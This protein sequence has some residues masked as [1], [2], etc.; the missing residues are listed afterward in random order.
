MGISVGMGVGVG[1]G[2]GIGI[3]PNYCGETIRPFLSAHPSILLEGLISSVYAGGLA[4]GNI[5]LECRFLHLNHYLLILWSHS[6]YLPRRHHAKTRL[7]ISD[8]KF[9]HSF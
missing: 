6:R 9:K 5:M 1:M 7:A 4:S 8:Y 3:L 2:M